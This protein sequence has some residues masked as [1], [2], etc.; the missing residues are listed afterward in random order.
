MV[1]A[2]YRVAALGN[3][4]TQP[5]HRGRGHAKAV[6]GTLCRHLMARAD[7]IGLNVKADNAAALGCYRALGFEVCASYEETMVETR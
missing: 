1:S 7:H 5:A 3:V 2:A 4:A 6:T